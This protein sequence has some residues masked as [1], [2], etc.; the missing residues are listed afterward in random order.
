MRPEAAMSTLTTNKDRET[1]MMLSLS[2][3]ERPRTLEEIG[4]RATDGIRAW[5]SRFAP[6]LVPERAAPEVDDPSATSWMRRFARDLITTNPLS[7]T[8]TPL[9]P[10]Q[11]YLLELVLECV[12]WP[13]L[14]SDRRL[15][16]LDWSRASLVYPR[17]CP[18]EAAAQSLTGG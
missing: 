6:G 16:R 9:V 18:D 10:V 2:F 17:A 7:P 4:E 12:D 5:L 8:R 15:R 1:M 3:L 13:A 11:L 14:A